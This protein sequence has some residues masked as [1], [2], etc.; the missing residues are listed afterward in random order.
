MK[1]RIVIEV[2]RRD[3]NVTDDDLRAATKSVK[4]NVDTID[5]NGEP[6]GPWIRIDGLR[7]SYRV[8]EVKP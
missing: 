7:W 5:I 1:A 2:E 4:K 3:G 6:L 8:E